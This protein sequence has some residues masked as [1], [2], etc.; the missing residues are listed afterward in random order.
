MPTAEWRRTNREKYLAQQR[1]ANAKTGEYRRDWHLRRRYGIGSADYERMYEA[2]D[3]RCA[4]CRQS[5]AQRFHV[6]H[7]HAS[8]RV[9]GL[10]CMRCNTAL[11]HMESEAWRIRAERYLA[12]SRLRREPLL[13][14]ATMEGCGS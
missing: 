14:D 13:A 10:L 4:I 6:D 2:Q 1:R 9:R 11:G 3:G 8:G 12:Y 5:S 7:D